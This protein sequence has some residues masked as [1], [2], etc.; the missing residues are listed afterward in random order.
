MKSILVAGMVAVGLL[1]AG[2]ASASEDMA[3]KGGCMTCHAVDAKKMG[4]ALKEVAKKYKGDAKA[5]A[6]LVE[7]LAK[8]QGHPEVKAKGDDL[9]AIVKWNLS[10]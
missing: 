2:A 5:E 9:K 6:T 7:K 4:P 10:L 1:A 3:K 8:A